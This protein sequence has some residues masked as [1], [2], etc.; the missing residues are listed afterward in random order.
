ME[1]FNLR[2]PILVCVLALSTSA[3]LDVEELLFEREAGADAGYRGAVMRDK[4]I[5]YWPLDETEGGSTEDASGN[6]YTAYINNNGGQGTVSFED[7]VIAGGAT[8]QANASL[9]VEAPHPL[10]FGSTSYTLEAWVRVDAASSSTLWSCN[11]G[12][13]GYTTFLDNGSINH[14]RYGQA[15]YE[16]M[17]E[18][19]ALQ[20]FRHLVVTYDADASAGLVYIDGS[21]LTLPA[22]T[23]ALTWGQVT[24]AFSLA[25]T[26]DTDLV[27]IDEV[28]LYD[29]ALT[30]SQISDHHLCGK[31]GPSDPSCN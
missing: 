10:G 13:G 23:L 31:N 15:D 12:N 30:A 16:S 5:A 28:A 8:L 11:D 1:E 26:G 3:C 9:F 7:A 14:K 18:M 17:N 2:S 29:K 21:I 27:A 4:P 20:Q 24:S 25:A 22:R 6:G 19:V